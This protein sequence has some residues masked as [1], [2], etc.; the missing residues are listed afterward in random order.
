MYDFFT[1]VTTFAPFF[2]LSRKLGGGSE[3]QN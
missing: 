2:S 3:M 1:I